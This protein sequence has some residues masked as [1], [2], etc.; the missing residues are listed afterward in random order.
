MF[1][2]IPKYF[3]E[4]YKTVVAPLTDLLAETDFCLHLY[5]E[6]IYKMTY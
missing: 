3:C 5:A 2:M 1:K 6:A 4:R